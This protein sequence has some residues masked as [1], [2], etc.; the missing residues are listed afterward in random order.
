MAS[1]QCWNCRKAITVP[2]K[3]VFAHPGGKHFVLLTKDAKILRRH[4]DPIGNEDQSS[5]V[6]AQVAQNPANPRVWGIRN[7][8]SNPWAAATDGTTVE[9]TPQKA[10]PLKAGL[11]MN[12]GGVSAEVVS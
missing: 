12:M 8:T 7:L 2:P 9:V 5:E 11:K 6:V 1:L 3:L 10:V 4:I